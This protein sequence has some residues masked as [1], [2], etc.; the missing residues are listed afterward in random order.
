MMVPGKNVSRSW[1]FWLAVA[2]ASCA[3]QAERKVRL[4]LPLL[5]DAGG[6]PARTP[7][8]ASE[9]LRDEVA[10]FLEP[11]REAG[12]TRDLAHQLEGILAGMPDSALGAVWPYLLDG[13]EAVA[14]FAAEYFDRRGRLA[15]VPR[16][17][18]LDYLVSRMEGVALF[19][20]GPPHA[21]LPHLREMKLLCRLGAS[22][23]R[24]MLAACARAPEGEL[25]TELL[26]VLA[27]L[28]G[29]SLASSEEVQ[30]WWLERSLDLTRAEQGF[31]VDRTEVVRRLKSRLRTHPTDVRALLGYA[32]AAP[33][34]AGRFILKMD[35]TCARKERARALAFVP[36]HLAV[37]VLCEMVIARETRVRV[38]AALALAC[39]RSPS[40]TPYL[41][42][43]LEYPDRRTRGPVALAL[44]LTA[45]PRAASALAAT[46]KYNLGEVADAAREG[47]ERVA[48]R[49]FAG[50]REF[51]EWFSAHGSELG[52]QIE[53][54]VPPG[55]KAWKDE[56]LSAFEARTLDGRPVEERVRFWLWRCD[57]Y[58]LP[59]SKRLVISD[60]FR[61]LVA[62]GDDAVQPLAAYLRG[63]PGTGR[64][65]AE[66]ALE[67]IASMPD[68]IEGNVAAVSS[69][70]AQVS[71][72]RLRRTLDVQLRALLQKSGKPPPGGMGEPV[73]PKARA[74]GASES[75]RCV[76]VTALGEIGGEAAERA[77]IAAQRREASER[78]LGSIEAAIESLGL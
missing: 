22:G 52:G 55:E 4:P 69:A 26:A 78:V 35:P 42:R 66:S 63:F 49:E 8:S 5:E 3:P 38:N 54:A 36:A 56:A 16:G 41:V 48:G 37:P 40:A 75:E 10:G 19:F 50:P 46:W 11:L 57:V 76:A 53:F 59:R 7:P 32:L 73:F 72:K 6:R 65:V 29:E 44:A 43:A 9:E 51:D 34:E 2:A 25:R 13:N 24:G 23:T 27:S 15:D 47:L 74:R 45:D 77:L 28:T 12:V 64:R 58:D 30:A 17:A 39:H 67:R 33:A 61:K 60:A 70:L 31:R 71:D 1:A 18:R 20:D 14:C 62:L 21:E 68:D